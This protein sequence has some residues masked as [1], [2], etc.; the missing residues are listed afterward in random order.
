MHKE[1][2]NCTK[3][4]IQ[5]MRNIIS[6]NV[7]SFIITTLY[8][9]TPGKCVDRFNKVQRKWHAHNLYSYFLKWFKICPALFEIIDMTKGKLKNQFY[10]V[11]KWC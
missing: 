5:L 6:I 4:I 1:M 9:Q 7:N 8:F 2:D 3:K 10:M 11:L